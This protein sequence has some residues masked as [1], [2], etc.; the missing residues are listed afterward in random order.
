M[1]HCA[2]AG[3]GG[4]RN[5]DKEELVGLEIALK[6]LEVDEE[7]ARLVLSNRR[8]MTENSVQAFNIGDVVE[9]TVQSV[10]PYGAFVDIGGVNGLLHISQISHDRISNVETVLQEGD[11]LKVG[12][13][14]TGCWLVGRGKVGLFPM[15]G[16]RQFFKLAMCGRCWKL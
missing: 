12:F 2:T 3:A 5:A 10:K 4:Q 7:R 9:G 15:V 16:H 13:R 14:G 1:P 11:T 8:A 6:V